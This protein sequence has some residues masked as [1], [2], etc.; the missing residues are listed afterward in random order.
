MDRKELHTLIDAALDSIGCDECKGVFADMMG[1]QAVSNAGAHNVKELTD[2]IS[3]GEI[4]PVAAY[5]RLSTAM[6][7]V[8]AAMGMTVSDEE[9]ARLRNLF[10][11]ITT[12]GLN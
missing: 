10:L 8:Y 5:D 4:T 12:S 9:H 3:A 2:K 7:P 1:A 11:R 6:R